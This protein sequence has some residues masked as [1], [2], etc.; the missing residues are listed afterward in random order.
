M[1]HSHFA[2]SLLF[3]GVVLLLL[4]G[5]RLTWVGILCI[6]FAIYFQL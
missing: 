1:Q 3:C 2:L 6:V 4:G 5:P